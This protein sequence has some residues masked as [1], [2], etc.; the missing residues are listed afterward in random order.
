MARVSRRIRRTRK[1]RFELRLPEL[2]RRALRSLP[3]QLRQLLEA[4]DPSVGRLFPPAYADDPERQE[5][6]ERLV[7]DDLMAQRLRGLEVMEQTLDARTL[8]EEGLLAWLGA[9]NDLRLVLG[10]QLGIEVETDGED[11]ADDDPQAPVVALYHF[12]GWL[13]S[14][15]IDALAEGLDPDGTEGE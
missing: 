7:K 14:Q 6:Y 9:L 2:E 15:V 3:G 5:E 4:N 11:V 10:T 12:L 13:E 8:D 1:G